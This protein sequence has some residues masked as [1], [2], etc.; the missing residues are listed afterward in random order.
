MD[1]QPSV[2]RGIVTTLGFLVVIAGL[3]WAVLGLGVLSDNVCEA[4][5]PGRVGECEGPLV[6]LVVRSLVSAGFGGCAILVAAK[7]RTAEMVWKG[8]IVLVLAGVFIS[9]IVVP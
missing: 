2:G 3:F 4:S 6:W 1:R 9:P 7:A 8:G 5:H